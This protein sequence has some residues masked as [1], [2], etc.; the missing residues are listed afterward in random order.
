MLADMSGYPPQG[1]AV[2]ATGAAIAAEIAATPRTGYA[3]VT[4]SALQRLRLRRV[5]EAARPRFFDGVAEAA[6]WLGWGDLGWLHAAGAGQLASVAASPGVA[7]GR[8]AR[9]SPALRLPDSR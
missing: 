1:P 6:V 9:N 8:P 5:L 2:N 3:V 7:V 4:G